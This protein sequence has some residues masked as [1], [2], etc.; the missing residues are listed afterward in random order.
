MR[1]PKNSKKEQLERR[2]L[3]TKLGRSYYFGSKHRKKGSGNIASGK[4]LEKAQLKRI[5]FE[6]LKKENVAG[7]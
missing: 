4:N 5:I 7:C 3:I 1:S 2:H 6:L